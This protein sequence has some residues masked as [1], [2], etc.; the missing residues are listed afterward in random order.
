MNNI[1]VTNPAAYQTGFNG[2]ALKVIFIKGTITNGAVVSPVDIAARGSNFNYSVAT[3]VTQADEINTR[4]VKETNYGR[5]E[6]GQGSLDSVFNL[7]ANDQL[8]TVNSLG[9]E[10]EY[11]I[12]E[13]TGD[14]HPLTVV[15][16]GVLS[17]VV[18]NAFLGVRIVNQSSGTVVN[19]QKMLQINVVFRK[20]LNGGD[21]KKLNAATNYPGTVS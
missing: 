12:L 2:T 1:V 9:E 17:P 10:Q 15:A 4:E 21:W 13:V 20:H 7:Q 5:Q 8:P 3:P 18:L 19:Q 6:L 14:D 16:A 11:T